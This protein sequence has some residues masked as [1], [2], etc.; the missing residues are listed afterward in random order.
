[1]GAA[2]RGEALSKRA[3]TTIRDMLLKPENGKLAEAYGK[4]I[5][6]GD[7]RLAADTMRKLLAK[8]AAKV[9]THPAAVSV[10]RINALQT[11][12]PTNNIR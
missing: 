1:M 10:G 2:L 11:Q 6:Q 8:K 7:K 3:A 9:I 5:A 12:E 4:A